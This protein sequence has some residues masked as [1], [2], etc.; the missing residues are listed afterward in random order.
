MSITRLNCLGLRCPLPIV[1]MTLEMKTLGEGDALE[2]EADD[3]AFEADL[4]AWI[5]KTGHE[6]VS[7][8]VRPNTRAL[9]KKVGP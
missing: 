6:L 3:L 7:L 5:K 9:I 1:K 2:V 4:E 8:E